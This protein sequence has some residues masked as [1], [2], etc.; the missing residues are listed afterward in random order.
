MLRHS[1]IMLNAINSMSENF[2]LVPR[3]RLGGQVVAFFGYF[4]TN[5]IFITSRILVKFVRMLGMLF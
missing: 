2:G 3:L 1:A 4:I 5:N